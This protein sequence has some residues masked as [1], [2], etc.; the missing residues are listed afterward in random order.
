M[1][2]KLNNCTMRYI[3]L[4]YTVVASITCAKGQKTWEFTEFKNQFIT[5]ADTVYVVNFCCR[6]G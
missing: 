1:F 5:S 3:F 6:M 4:L 2:T